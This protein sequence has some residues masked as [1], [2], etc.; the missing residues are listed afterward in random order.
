MSYTSVRL[1]GHGSAEHM[2]YPEF[3]AG[4]APESRLTRLGHLEARQRGLILRREHV[5]IGG[6]YSATL[7]RATESLDDIADGAGLL[8]AEEL[9]SCA[10]LNEQCLGQHEGRLRTD[11]YTETVTAAMRSQGA[12]YVHPGRNR[13]GVQGESLVAA[14]ERMFSFLKQVRKNHAG[15]RGQVIAITSKIITRG[16]VAWIELGDPSGNEIP[17]PVAMQALVNNNMGWH[18]TLSPCSETVLAV[19]GGPSSLRVIIEDIGRELPVP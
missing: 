13:A 10:E 18:P 8:Y 14:T 19:E 3:V 6:L 9:I 16:M 11:A 7:P 5:E 15:Y 12:A 4:Q 17:D 1:I 2:E